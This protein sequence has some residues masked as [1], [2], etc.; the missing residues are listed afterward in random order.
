[1]NK[2][3]TE[4]SYNKTDSCVHS[5]EHGYKGCNFHLSFGTANLGKFEVVG[6]MMDV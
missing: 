6:S 2:E 1:M 3:V 4:V 5:E